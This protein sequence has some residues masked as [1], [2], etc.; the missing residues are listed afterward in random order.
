MCQRERQRQEDFNKQ[1]DD[2]AYY[3]AM[4]KA[5]EQGIDTTFNS[6]YSAY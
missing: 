4:D 3:A 6:P 1:M 5:R 2:L